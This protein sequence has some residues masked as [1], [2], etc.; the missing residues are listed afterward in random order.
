MD[1][2]LDGKCAIVTGGSRGIGKA[3]AKG[4]ALEG[5]DLALVARDESALAA[6]ATEIAS[7]TGRRVVPIVA[8]TGDDA[9]VRAMVQRAVESLG[10]VDIL[11]NAAAKPGGQG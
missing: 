3:V 4:L 10:R 8:D 7:L 9:S 1:L 5:V 11:V 2:Q 6:A